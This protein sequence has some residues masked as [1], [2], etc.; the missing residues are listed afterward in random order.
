MVIHVL[1]LVIVKG[2]VQGILFLISERL[3]LVGAPCWPHALDFSQEMQFPALSMR[4]CVAR[5]TQTTLCTHELMPGKKSITIF[6]VVFYMILLDVCY[7]G[8]QANGKY[9]SSR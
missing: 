7:L 3:C 8:L 9:C 5:E 4:G 2:M 1:M 6:S